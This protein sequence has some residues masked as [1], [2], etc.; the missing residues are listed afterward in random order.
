MPHEEIC[1]VLSAWRGSVKTVSH[2]T[3]KRYF[4]AELASSKARLK[5]KIMSKWMKRLRTDSRSYSEGLHCVVGWRDNAPPPIE[6]KQTTIKVEFVAP[7]AKP[8]L[9]PLE[10]TPSHIPGDV[11]PKQRSYDVIALPPPKPSSA[12]AD[13]RRAEVG[14]RPANGKAATTKCAV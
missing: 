13:L 9:P 5:S 12:S 11:P 6:Q 3:L 14:S 2:S 1:H 10:H 8:I 4:K 7:P